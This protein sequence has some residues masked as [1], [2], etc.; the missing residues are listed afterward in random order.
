[1]PPGPRKPIA[2]SFKVRADELSRLREDWG[3]TIEQLAAKSAVSVN[4]IKRWLNGE[5]ATLTS[6]AKVAKALLV[7]CDRLIE[8]NEAQ[9]ASEI[10]P[11][12]RHIEVAIEIRVPFEEFTAGNT[13]AEF[14]KQLAAA[15]NC[16]SDI[17]VKDV[18][19][20]STILIVEMDID[21]FVKLYQTGRKSQLPDS[22]IIAFSV[23]IPSPRVHDF[24]DY[25]QLNDD[26]SSV[27][28]DLIVVPRVVADEL[29]DAEIPIA[30]Y[31][32][33]LVFHYVP[34]TESSSHIAS[35]GLGKEAD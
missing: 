34:Q 21:D 30:S 7:G 10:P 2:Q 25:I 23:L 8:R 11:L 22:G 9:P 6:I 28:V 3:F 19:R 17:T 5:P 4:T 24:T 13:I 29:I 1:M 20:G 32:L 12:G 26:I 27:F 15:I 33:L 35:K 14:I 16:K 31:D 18:Q